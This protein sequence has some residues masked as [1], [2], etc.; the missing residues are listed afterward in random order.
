M[1]DI[2]RILLNT[3]QLKSALK[4]LSVEQLNKVISSIKQIALEHEEEEELARLEAEENEKKIKELLEIAEEK[5]VD[6]EALKTQLEVT[7]TPKRRRKT[8]VM[9]YQYKDINGKS[10]RWSGQG[11]QPK[12][13]QEAIQNDHKTLEDF[14]IEDSTS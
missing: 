3:R 5:G 6:L 1:N 11:R 14:L 10:K 12:E 13:I 9:K 8:S 7:T 4:N 2:N